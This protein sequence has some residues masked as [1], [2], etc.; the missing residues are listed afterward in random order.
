[1]NS[2]IEAQ[3]DFFHDRTISKPEPTPNQPGS[4]LFSN[5]LNWGNLFDVPKQ[6][7]DKAPVD[8]MYVYEL[9]DIVITYADEVYRI[10]KELPE[11]EAKK[12]IGNLDSEDYPIYI[13]QFNPYSAIHNLEYEPSKRGLGYLDFLAN[14]AAPVNDNIVRWHEESFLERTI[15]HIK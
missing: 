3:F 15:T 11:S 8:K 14:M 2:I 7:P 12:A 5:D 1:M 4:L 10:C 13:K 9:P 6:L